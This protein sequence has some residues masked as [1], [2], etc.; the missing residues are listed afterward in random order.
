MII[1]YDCLKPSRNIW[2]QTWDSK[3]H[4]R[5]TPNYFAIFCNNLFHL[6]HVVKSLLSID[7]I[8]M[9]N[10]P[11]FQQTLFSGNL[12][13]I[14]YFITDSL[15]KLRKITPQ[16]ILWNFIFPFL[17]LNGLQYLFFGFWECIPL[18]IIICLFSLV[19]R[20]HAD[21]TF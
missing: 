4:K 14:V 8:Y 15:Y 6:W 13:C 16:F 5:T 19:Y 7:R 12:E 2:D 11:L 1:T 17:I 18:S 21:T 9:Y 20:D 10:G 3:T